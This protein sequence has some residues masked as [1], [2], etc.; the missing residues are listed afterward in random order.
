MQ[1]PQPAWRRCLLASQHLNGPRSAVPAFCEFL[2]KLDLSCM[3]SIAGSPPRLYL[4]LYPGIRAPVAWS[5]G[6][7]TCRV[8]LE[9]GS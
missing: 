8:L 7:Q 4:S 5:S 6:H 1:A 3:G 2:P 9:A